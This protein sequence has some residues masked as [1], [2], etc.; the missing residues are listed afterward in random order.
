MEA[1]SDRYA[2]GKYSSNVLEF[3]LLDDFTGVSEGPLQAILQNVGFCLPRY[4]GDS[5][6]CRELLIFVKQV[7]ETKTPAT[8]SNF[9]HMLSGIADPL[10]FSGSS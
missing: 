5:I 8:Y 6:S 2:Q 7:L 9:L 3:Q 10:V 4:I 1:G